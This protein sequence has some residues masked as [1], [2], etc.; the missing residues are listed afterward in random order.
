MVLHQ[1]DYSGKRLAQSI[2]SQANDI[3]LSVQVFSD[4]IF[5][6]CDIAGRKLIFCHDTGTESNVLGSH[7][8]NKVINTVGVY[9]K[10][11]L[12][13][14][15]AQSVEALNGSTNDFTFGKSRISGMNT[16]ITILGAMSNSYSV[17]I[18]GGCWAVIFWREAVFI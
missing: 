11:E 3:N 13:G 18:D 15:G 10:S 12:R 2:G 8:P 14:A 16:I 9:R 4:V 17:R 7:L 1:L 6:D 5:V